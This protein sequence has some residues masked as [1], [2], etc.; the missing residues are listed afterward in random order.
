MPKQPANLTG[1]R[2]GRLVAQQYAAGATGSWV[3][4]CD[5]G[6]IKNI[7]SQKLRDGSTKSCG[8]LRREVASKRNVT[9]DEYKHRFYNTWHKMLNRCYNKKNNQYHNYGGRGITVCDEWRID[10]NAFLSWC[11]SKEPIP[12]GFSIDRYPNQNGPYSSE[13]CRFA[14]SHDQSR[15]TRQ[16]V[17]VD[18]NGEHLIFEDFVTKYGQVS[19]K[20]A[21]KRIHNYGWELLEAVFTPSLGHGHRRVIK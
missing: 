8:C 13:N 1:Q 6:T 5:C 11:D 19:S 4:A 9:H 10:L 2:F 20:L 15:N 18:Y 3:C 7:A 16:N 12:R 14:S 21:S 17:W